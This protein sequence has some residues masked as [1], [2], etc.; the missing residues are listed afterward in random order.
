MNDY[1]ISL[2]SI[3][4]TKS[5]LERPSTKINLSVENIDIN[6]KSR[7]E[8]IE[9][10]RLNIYLTIHLALKNSDTFLISAEML[11]VFQYKGNLPFTIEDF[12]TINASAIIFPFLREH[13]A[14]LTSKAGLNTLLLPPL[15]F[16][17]MANKN[18]TK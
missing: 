15:N 1:T 13:I 7:Y 4:L 6:V 16:V 2:N 14:S 12:S 18:S 8:E 3:I 11:G 17:A 9:N 5:I 10:N